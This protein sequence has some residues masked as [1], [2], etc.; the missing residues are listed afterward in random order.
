MTSIKPTTANQPTSPK[1]PVPSQLGT[2]GGGLVGDV[3]Q[4]DGSLTRG[5]ELVAV[6]VLQIGQRYARIVTATHTQ[7]K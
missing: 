5:L 2:E 4:H 7:K 6:V 1:L 3:A